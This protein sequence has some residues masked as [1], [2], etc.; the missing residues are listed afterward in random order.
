M[1]PVFGTFDSE[2]YRLEVGDSKFSYSS[3]EETLIY[4]SP[5]F[6]PNALDD[7][8]VNKVS[9]EASSFTVTYDIA[10]LVDQVQS[11]LN[12]RDDR[13]LCA[14][15]LARHFLPSYVYLELAGSGGSSSSAISAIQD[16]ILAMEPEDVLNVSVLE[17]LLHS[18]GLSSY[19]H[20]IELAVVTHDLDRRYVLTRNESSISDNSLHINGSNRITFYIPGQAG[21]DDSTLGE[22]ISIVPEAGD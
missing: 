9:L 21:V 22:R 16:H 10:P 6:L 3:K 18:S 14:N 7:V 8:E 19:T 11:L 17:G 4:F 12:S 20:P 1:V 2:G 5:R 13:I 15:P